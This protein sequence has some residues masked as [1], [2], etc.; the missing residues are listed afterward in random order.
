MDVHRRDASLA[1]A[2]HADGGGALVV[3][4]GAADDV[5]A[6]GVAVELGALGTVVGPSDGVRVARAPAAEAVAER[7]VLLRVTAVAEE[8]A[9]ALAA[10]GRV[11]LSLDL[12]AR[13][14]ITAVD[15]VGLDA[16]READLGADRHRRVAWQVE[17]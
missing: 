9:V 16:L 8:A 5:L 1:M 4:A 11:G 13:H 15:E 2:V 7:D 17:Q 6:G 14:V 12:V 3:A 10:A